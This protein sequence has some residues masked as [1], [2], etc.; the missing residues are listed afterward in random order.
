MHCNANG[1]KSKL[2]SLVENSKTFKPDIVSITESKMN[3]MESEIWLEGYCKPF[4]LRR[5][6]KLGGGIWISHT[7]RSYNKVKVLEMGDDDNQIWID[8]KIGNKTLILG[9]VYGKQET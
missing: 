5:E 8:I 6:R 3:P 4:E 7:K 1:L 2:D 9:V